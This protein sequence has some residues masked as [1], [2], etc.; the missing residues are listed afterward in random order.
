MRSRRRSCCSTQNELLRKYADLAANPDVVVPRHGARGHQGPVDAALPERRVE[1]QGRP[2]RELRPRAHGAL[3][4]RRDARHHGRQELQRERRRAAREVV[5]RLVHRRQGSRQRQV[6][7]STR[8]RWFNGPK[9][10]FGKLGNYNTDSVVDLVLG[11]DGHAP[12]IVKKLWGEFMPTPPSTATL[13]AAR[14]RL[15]RGRPQ[16]QAAPAQHPHATRS[17]SSRSTSPT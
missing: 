10:I 5:H 15:H 14:D 17:S 11:Q 9:S 13:A 16:D 1:R 7:A 2:E 6:A 4:A 8:G 3:H 12:Y